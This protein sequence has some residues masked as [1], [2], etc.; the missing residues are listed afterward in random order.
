M[1]ILTKKV[2]TRGTEHGYCNICGEWKKLTW[3][4]IPPKGSIK[5]T[6]VGLKSL[7][8][9]HEKEKLASAIQRISQNG[10]KF[11]SI[12][13]YCNNTRLGKNFDPYLNDFSR[14][15]AQIIK[16]N[17]NIYLPSSFPVTL[18]PQR[19]ARSV[20]GHLLAAEIRENMQSPLESV[21]MKDAM[22][23][24]FLN[25]PQ[26]LPSELTLYFWPYWLN[27][28][29]L[30][31]GVYIAD[32]A[33]VSSTKENCLVGDFL[34]YPPFCFFLAFN[35]SQKSHQKFARFEILIRSHRLDQDG[36]A[37]INMNTI[38]PNWPESPRKNEILF[39]NSD[40]CLI[41]EEI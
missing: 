18:K 30:L 41:A 5:P 24:Y 25:T 40:V 21:P 31:R 11:R 14:N 15:V 35:I 19:V 1:N 9:F 16:L 22:R 37:L 2:Q 38:P 6:K 20:I 8:Q 4:H 39:I 10:L 12:C 29:V 27:R 33:D 28:R 32:N 13:H 3:D 7:S 23:D 34:K 26:D 17:K 36:E